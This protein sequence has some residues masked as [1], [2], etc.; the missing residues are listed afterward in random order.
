MFDVEKSIAD[1]QEKFN[2]LAAYVREDAQHEEA[3][4]VERRLFKGGMGL[5]LH[6]L[7]AYF[8]GK[9]GGDM[10]QAIKTPSGERLGRERL[11][12]C[13]YLTVFGE[14]TLHRWYYHEDGAAGVLPLD[15]STNLPRRKYSYFLQELLAQR[16]GRM[17]YDDALAEVEQIFGFHV[18]KHSVEDMA[19]EAARDVDAYYE[20]QGTPPPES[21]AEVLV[22]AIDG[23]GVPI[24]KDGPAEHRVRLRKG[25]KRSRKKEAVVSAVYTIAAEPRTAE[26]VIREVREHESPPQRPKPQNKRLRATLE[27]KTDA[28]EWVRREVERRDGERTKHRVCLMD[29][30]RGLWK[31]ARDTLTG[32]TFILDLFHALEYLWKAAYVFHPEGSAEAE[33]FVRDRL[34]MLLEGKV[35]YV[36]GGLRQMLTK[37]R[38]TLRKSQRKTLE[39]VIGYYH[40]NRRWMRYDQYIAAGYPIGSGAVEGACRHLVKERMEGSGMRWTV[41]GAAS[42]LQLRAA[43]LNGDWDAFWA[44]H[45]R[46]EAQ[47]RFTQKHWRP[48]ECLEPRKTAA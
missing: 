27:G 16:V 47:R 37:H 43:V 9:E 14:L 31:A 35:G 12:P 30:S 13:Q 11:K 17:A 40:A 1:A 44:F 4:V 28:F 25:E 34:R 8:E 15:E 19:G 38:D 46:C 10:G 26:D 22:A 23:K 3:Y 32:F 21:E 7:A 6:L 20:Q 33:A 41:K 24:L 5:L 29:G 2:R 18:H 48:V 36:I 42:V 39:T 45:M